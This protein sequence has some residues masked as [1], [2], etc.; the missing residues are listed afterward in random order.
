M[1]ISDQHRHACE[2]R[3]CV[4]NFYPDGVRMA[5]HMAW[6][7]T[8]RG[9]PAADRLRTGVREAWRAEMASAKEPS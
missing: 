9:K 5:A 1:L 7:E 3:W 2:I 8:Y 4:Q 6:V